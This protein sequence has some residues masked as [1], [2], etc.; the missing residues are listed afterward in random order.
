MYDL[1]LKGGTVLDPSSKLD[2]K[3]DVAVEAGKIA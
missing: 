2:G 1:V 3:Q